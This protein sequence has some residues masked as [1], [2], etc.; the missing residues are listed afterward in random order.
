MTDH[1]S[2]YF[3][4]RSSSRPSHRAVFAQDIVSLKAEGYGSRAMYVRECSAQATSGP[5]EADITV[6]TR[7]ASS[8]GSH[9]PSR[10][11]SS[12]IACGRSTV[13]VSHM[14]ACDA[15]W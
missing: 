4:A 15:T 8:R 9:A 10:R 3:V 7:L 12:R 13:I 1:V 14:P 5:I 6:P 11:R 2:S